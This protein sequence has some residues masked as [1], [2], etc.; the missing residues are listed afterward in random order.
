MEEYCEKFIGDCRFYALL[1]NNNIL[2]Y[3]MTA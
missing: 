3:F 2:K 1:A